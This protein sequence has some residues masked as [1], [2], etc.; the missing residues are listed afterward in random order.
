MI[1]LGVKYVVCSKSDAEKKGKASPS[2]VLIL[3][4]KEKPKKMTFEHKGKS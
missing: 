1:S 4:E 2:P 3:K